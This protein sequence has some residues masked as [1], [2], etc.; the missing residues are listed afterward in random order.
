MIFTET[1]SMNYFLSDFG[2]YFLKREALLI[3]KP[4]NTQF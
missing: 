1:L 2:N 4:I 3:I